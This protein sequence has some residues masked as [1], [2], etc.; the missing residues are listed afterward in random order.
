MGVVVSEPHDALEVARLLDLAQVGAQRRQAAD[1]SRFASSDRVPSRPGRG[2]SIRISLAAPQP[3]LLA[4]MVGDDAPTGTHVV[5]A[6]PEENADHEAVKRGPALQP[7]AI[8]DS[9]ACAT[10]PR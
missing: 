3:H 2:S 7:A 5:A 1:G 6:L 8:P 10:G 4:E 9:C